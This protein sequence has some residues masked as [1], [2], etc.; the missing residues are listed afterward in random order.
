MRKLFPTS[1]K[2]YFSLGLGINFLACL[3]SLG[4]CAPRSQEVAPEP[5]DTQ[6]MH[7]YGMSVPEEKWL[8]QGRN[9][10]V[11]TTSNNGVIASQTYYYGVL[12]GESTW[13]YPFSSVIQKRKQYSHGQLLIDTAYYSSGSKKQEWSLEPTEHAETLKQW[14]ENGQLSSEEKISGKLL[15][16]G[17]YY[18]PQGQKLSAVSDGEGQRTT[19][20]TF[21]TLIFTEKY[22]SGEKE[23]LTSYYPD[24]TPK[25]MD[26][27]VNGMVE[28]LRKTYYPG[29]EPK[30]LENWR[31]NKQDGVTTVFKD[32]E[33]SEEITYVNGYK[34]GAG[35]LFKDGAIVVQEVTWKNDQKHGKCTTYIDNR[36]VTE[37]YFRGQKVTK[38]YWDSFNFKPTIE[39]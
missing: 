36:K 9:G 23:Y 29:G 14:Y 18:D 26:P 34:N 10:Q 32:G 6:Y 33:K 37:W 7:R 4:S 19:K 25:E 16:H 24:G 30:T 31:A 28:G 12:D 20:D 8:E 2:A 5:V 27:Y 15:V 39:E 35:R 13:T 11:V 38:A 17:T 21:G 3:V 22:H 1:P